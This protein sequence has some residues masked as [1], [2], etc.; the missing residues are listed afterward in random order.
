MPPY[1]GKIPLYMATERACLKCRIVFPYTSEFFGKTKA[2]GKPRLSPYCKKCRCAAAKILGAPY[3]EKARLDCLTH[4]SGGEPKCACCDERGILF[5]AI[6]H[7]NGGGGRERKENKTRNQ[8][9]RLRQKGYPPGLQVLCH[10]C[11]CSLGK[12]GYCPHRPEEKRPVLTGGR[13][14]KPF[15]PALPIFGIKTCFKCGVLKPSSENYF[16][17]HKM[18]ANGFLGKCREC[19]H[20]YGRLQNKTARAKFR[21]L[22]LQAYGGNNPSCACCGIGHQE[23]LSID[24]IHGGGA[25]HRKAVGNVYEFLVKSNF[26]NG[27]RLLCHS[28]NMALGLYG[29]CH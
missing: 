23:F 25:K 26:P 29:K 15:D 8:Y 17:R 18:M 12:Y 14:E 5:L 19:C 9:V 16:F 6:D 13:K 3:R 10:N 24:H 28:C 4:Y 21:S 11:N 22:V 7:L 1:E 2:R 27:F 20:I